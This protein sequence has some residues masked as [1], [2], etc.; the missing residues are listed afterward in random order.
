LHSGPEYDGFVQLLDMGKDFD[1][2]TARGHDQYD[3]IVRQ[4]S[5]TSARL[6]EA[7]KDYA[8]YEKTGQLRRPDE[9]G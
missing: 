4:L 5:V 3:L 1:A 2:A 8:H 6:T 9:F 7:L